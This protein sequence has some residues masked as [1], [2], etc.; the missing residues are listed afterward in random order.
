[1][2]VSKLLVLMPKLLLLNGNSKLVSLKELK[3]VTTCG[4]PDT[5]LKDLEKNSELILITIQNQYLEIGTD[6]VPIATTQILR[7]EERVVT[8]TLLINSFHCWIKHILKFLNYMA[9]IMRKD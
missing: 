1:M 2:P 6:Q 8:T 7:L 9:Q 5:F 4:W 3:S